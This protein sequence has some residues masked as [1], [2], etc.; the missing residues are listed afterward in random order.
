[1]AASKKDSDVRIARVHRVRRMLSDGTSKSHFYHRPTKTALPAPY[2][3]TFEAAYEA[4]EQRHAEPNKGNGTAPKQSTAPIAEGIKPKVQN[5]RSKRL[6]AADR[7]QV[8]KCDAQPMRDDVTLEAVEEREPR[9]Y[10][11]PEEVSLRWRRKIDVETLAN[12]RSAKIGP[13]Y[14]KFGKAVLYP[15]DLLKVWEEKNLIMCE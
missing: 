13:P 8:G 7:S 14:N 5:G 6:G 1:M 4:A 12:W 15:L 2:E 11:T 9:I 10:L 3:P